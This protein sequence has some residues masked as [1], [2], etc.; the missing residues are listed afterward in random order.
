MGEIAKQRNQAAENREGSRRQKGNLEESQFE[1]KVGP[2]A[3]SDGSQMIHYR[4]DE[5]TLLKLG[6]AWMFC[7]CGTVGI[8]S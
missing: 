7:S 8:S 3:G 2:K 6:K 4:L 5:F 1:N